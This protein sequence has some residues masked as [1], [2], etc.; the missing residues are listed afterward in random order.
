MTVLPPTPSSSSSNKLGVCWLTGSGII[1]IAHIHID[2]PYCE[3]A[4]LSESE[5]Y[6]VNVK[7][8]CAIS[9]TDYVAAVKIKEITEEAK[10]VIYDVRGFQK[11]WESKDMSR[12]VVVTGL[13][14]GCEPEDFG[15]EVIIGKNKNSG[16][17]AIAT[18]DFGEA[19]R[20]E[21]QGGGGRVMSEVSILQLV[22]ATE[23]E[24]VRMRG[25]AQITVGGSS[26]CMESTKGGKRLVVG[27]DEDVV[28]LGFG[29][30]PLKPNVGRRGI[31]GKGGIE[32]MGEIKS[33]SRSAITALSVVGEGGGGRQDNRGGACCFRVCVAELLHGLALYRYKESGGGG[34]ELECLWVKNDAGLMCTSLCLRW[35][36][37]GGTVWVGEQSQETVLK[38]R[39]DEVDDVDGEEVGEGGKREGEGEGGN[40]LPA[41]FDGGSAASKKGY[42]GHLFKESVVGCWGNHELY[43]GDEKGDGEEVER[44]NIIVG[45]VGDGIFAIGSEGTVVALS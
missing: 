32:I 29:A 11:V 39:V 13:C 35:K 21:E 45:G 40:R 26:F 22:P 43:G 20:R 5:E 42:M 30:D 18:V 28:V 37:R 15:G 6:G 1:K 36:G 17:I 34:G 3:V 4:N 33:N 14:Q 38:I 12:G 23:T 8:V 2:I 16:C 27:L 25:I 44:T 31:K 24:G 9:G 19:A 10:I 41:V 7:H